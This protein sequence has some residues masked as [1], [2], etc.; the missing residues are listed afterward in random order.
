MKLITRLHIQIPTSW[1][2]ELKKIAKKHNTTMTNI[3]LQEIIRRII[4]EY[5]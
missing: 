3:V 1:K 4:K 2:K 5:R